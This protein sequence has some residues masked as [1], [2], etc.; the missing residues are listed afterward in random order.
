MYTFV[1]NFVFLS[2]TLVGSSY[3]LKIGGNN[4]Q[5]Y[6][7]ANPDLFFQVII[8]HCILL[9]SKWEAFQKDFLF[10]SIN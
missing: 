2:V 4:T 1:I 9:S 6:I 7:V 8:F 10:G 5:M 3:F